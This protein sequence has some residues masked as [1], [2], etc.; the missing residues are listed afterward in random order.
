MANANSIANE[1]Q[2]VSASQYAKFTIDDVKPNRVIS[3]SS[4]SDVEAALK[5]ATD[6]RTSVIPVGGRTM[7]SLGNPPEHYDLALDMSRMNRIVEYEANDFTISV[8]AGMTLAQLQ[9]QLA[10]HGQFLPLDHPHFEHATLGGLCAVG[11]GGLRRNTF[12]GPR[13]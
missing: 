8:E 2:P 7:L 6:S 3:P 1:G 5:Q 10:E 4:S 11:R 13:D 12:G 9:Q